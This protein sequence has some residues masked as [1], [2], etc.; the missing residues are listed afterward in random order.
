MDS[1]LD[2]LHFGLC[3]RRHDYQAAR[4]ALLDQ[5]GWVTWAAEQIHD[6]APDAAEWLALLP[7][8]LLHQAERLLLDRQTGAIYSLRVGLNTI[9]RLRNNDIV[10][11]DS[12]ISRRHCVVLVH[13]GDRCELHDTAS[14]NGTYV[15][16]KRLRRPV[17][18]RCGDMIQVCKRKIHLATAEDNSEKMD[19]PDTVITGPF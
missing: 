12:G 19:A 8:K 1:R 6:A 11:E 14:R 3:S 9:G 15:N 7:D 16:G 4:A 18:L 13:A 10:F 17:F 5:R 2:S